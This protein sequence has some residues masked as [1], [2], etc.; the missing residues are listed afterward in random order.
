MK[1]EA[2]SQT[3]TNESSVGSRLLEGYALL[4]PLGQRLGRVERV[5]C[6]G[7]GDPQYVRVGIGFLGRTLV[8]VPV[9]D[10]TIDAELRTITLR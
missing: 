10:V 7:A 4:D 8:L 1:Q 9:L 2:G 5:F 6:N 3:G